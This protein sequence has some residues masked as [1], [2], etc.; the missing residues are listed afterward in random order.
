MNPAMLVALQ[1]MIA[2]ADAIRGDLK[3]LTEQY[4]RDQLRDAMEHLRAARSSLA[5]K[6]D[7]LLA[8]KQRDGR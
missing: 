8:A 2:L 7:A 5:P 3:G 1:E 6:I 4:E